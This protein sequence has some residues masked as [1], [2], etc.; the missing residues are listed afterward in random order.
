MSR[1]RGP[2]GLYE[3]MNGLALERERGGGWDNE[4]REGRRFFQVLFY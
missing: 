4:D 1:V 3:W 2:G